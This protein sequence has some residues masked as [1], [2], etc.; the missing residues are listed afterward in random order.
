MWKGTCILTKKVVLPY[1][2]RGYFLERAAGDQ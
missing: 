1:S 2:S